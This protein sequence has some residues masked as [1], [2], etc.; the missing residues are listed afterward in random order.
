MEVVLQGHPPPSLPR[1]QSALKLDGGGHLDR[2]LLSEGFEELLPVIVK[3]SVDFHDG[4]VLD[5]PQLTA[6][7]TYQPLVVADDND[8]LRKRNAKQKQLLIFELWPNSFIAVLFI[9]NCQT[10]ESW[11]LFILVMTNCTASFRVSEW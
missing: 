1:K 10:H 6:G 8:A 5:D 9:E 3:V 4:F 11:Q 2:D 7:V